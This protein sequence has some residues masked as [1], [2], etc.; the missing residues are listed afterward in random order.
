MDTDR[1]EV[2]A[3]LA[4]VAALIIPV[5]TAIDAAEMGGFSVMVPSM[6]KVLDTLR[7]AFI[8]VYGDVD[9]SEKSL[10]GQLM[11]NMAHN[12]VTVNQQISSLWLALPPKDDPSDRI[13][14]WMRPAR[15]T[16]RENAKFFSEKI[17]ELPVW[18]KNF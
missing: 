15:T 5:P 9:L 1:R 6:A 7:I 13:K 8:E 2:L 3:G 4:A 10:H 12:I 17:L 16:G 11:G 18:G 14:E